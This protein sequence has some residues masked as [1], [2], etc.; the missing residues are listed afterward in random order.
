MQV[1]R[2]AGR[3]AAPAKAARPGAATAPCLG[4]ASIEMHRAARGSPRSRAHRPLGDG[5]LLRPAARR[6]GL[7]CGPGSGLICG[8]CRLPCG[9]KRITGPWRCPVPGLESE[10][11]GTAS[12]S[13]RSQPEIRDCLLLIE[14]K[15]SCT[16][17]RARVCENWI[18]ILSVNPSPEQRGIVH[19]R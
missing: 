17:Y 9:Q 8:P 2:A 7:I 6:S 14:R 12:S 5:D 1:S 13:Q 19:V 15:H 3:S 16:Y 11:A 18:A 10:R 4:R